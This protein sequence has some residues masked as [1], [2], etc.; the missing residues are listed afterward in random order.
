[1]NATT[2][3]KLESESVPYINIPNLMATDEGLEHFLNV[4]DET[5]KHVEPVTASVMKPEMVKS[6]DDVRRSEVRFGNNK[7]VRHEVFDLVNQV[8]SSL[9]A[10]DLYN[11]VAEMQHTTYYDSVKGHYDWH[12]DDHPLSG[13]WGFKKSRKIS[14][15]LQLSEYGV[16]YEGGEL[17]IHGVN[18]DPKVLGKKGSLT[19]FPSIVRHR[20]AP[21]TKGTRQSLVFWY[22]GP[23]WR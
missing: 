7:W 23:R 8:N 15:T 13:R 19:I 17:E 1:M 5:F 3:I 9:W 14:C 20:V 4:I 21:V 10:L 11:A 18:T 6:V 16:D 22:Y 2:E 12:E